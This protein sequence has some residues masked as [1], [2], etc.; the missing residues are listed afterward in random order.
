MHFDRGPQQESVKQTVSDGLSE[1]VNA[2]KLDRS[3]L[4]WVWKELPC[5]VVPRRY[6]RTWRVESMRTEVAWCRWEVRRYTTVYSSGYR[7]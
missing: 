7:G 4:P 5:V 6:L 3:E 1:G 2:R